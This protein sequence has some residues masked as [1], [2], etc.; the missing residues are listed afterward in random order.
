MRRKRTGSRSVRTYRPR[1]LDHRGL[2]PAAEALEP[3]LLLA[4]SVLTYHNDGASTGQDLAETALTP[5]DVNAS[6]FGKLATTSLDGT[7]YAQPLYVAGVAVSG[8]GVHNVVYVATE[9]DS[10]YAID[11]D[12]GAVLWQDSFIDPAAGITTVPTPTSAPLTSSPRSASRHPGHR[13]GHRRHLRG[14]RDQ[15]RR[16]AGSTITSRRC[17][18]S[19]SAAAPRRSAARP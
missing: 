8:Q 4:A 3:R 9:H 7:V 14:G 10:L 16:R 5:A 2:G 19:T 17:T 13:P 6:Q 1:G 12:T 18:R 15:G 11:A